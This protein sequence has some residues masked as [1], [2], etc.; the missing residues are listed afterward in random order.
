MKDSV[1]QLI[2]IEVVVVVTVAIGVVLSIIEP[3]KF[4]FIFTAIDI[5]ALF[6]LIRL[7]RGYKQLKKLEDSQEIPNQP[8]QYYTQNPTY[9]PV[10]SEHPAYSTSTYQTISR[11][12]NCGASIGPNESF[13]QS[14]GTKK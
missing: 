11:C 8:Q 13:C 7:I 14:C 9:L 5:G 4:F 2:V 1:K 10:A 6:V 3:D 12:T